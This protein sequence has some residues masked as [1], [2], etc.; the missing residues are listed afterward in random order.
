MSNSWSLLRSHLRS[1]SSSRVR[2][3]S[4][5]RSGVSRWISGDVPAFLLEV[6]AVRE[7]HLV[8]STMAFFFF[9]GGV[10]FTVSSAVPG[11]AATSN[12]AAA[13][14]GLLI[15]GGV[16]ESPAAA[17]MNAAIAASVEAVLS[18]TEEVVTFAA[19]AGTA[20]ASAAAAADAGTS[21]AADAGKAAAA[22]VGTAAAADVGT[23]AVRAAGA[24]F[25]ASAA[26]LDGDGRCLLFSQSVFLCLCNSLLLS[27]AGRF[28]LCF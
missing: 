25:S 22:D 20:A 8:G 12:F 18:M 23:A 7:L 15:A 26:A 1:R 9:L 16:G 24:K 19:G 14:A 10:A 27:F 28:F 6:T 5:S 3:R 21:A 2:S 13:M 11:M 17:C 4:R